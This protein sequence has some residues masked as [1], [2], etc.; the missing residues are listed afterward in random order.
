IFISPNGGQSW[1]PTKINSILQVPEIVFSLAIDP[2]ETKKLYAG[3][4]RG[5]FRGLNR[6]KKWKETDLNDP[7]MDVKSLAIDPANRSTIYAAVVNSSNRDDSGIYK[8]T[9]GGEGWARLETGFRGLS[10]AS[11]AVDP[12]NPSTIYAGLQKSSIIFEGARH[13]ESAQGGVLK[14]TDGGSHWVAAGLNDVS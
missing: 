14:S 13:A 2:K 3:T 12:R 9:D 10:I 4:T 7:S 6:G 1:E 11:I 5:V 8:S